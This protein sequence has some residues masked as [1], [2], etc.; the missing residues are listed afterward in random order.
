M[1]KERL[2]LLLADEVLRKLRCSGGLG[3]FSTQ[4]HHAYFLGAIW[5]DH[6]FYDLPSFKTKGVGRALHVL[7]NPEDFPVLERWIQRQERL[8]DEVKA[9]VL[10]LSCHFLADSLWHPLIN[11]LSRPPFGPCASLGLKPGDCHHYIE[12]DLEVFWLDRRGP[13]DGY[14][15]LLT[16]LAGET[17]LVDR[18]IRSFRDL[19]KA[20]NIA[21]IP[22]AARL[23]RCLRWQNV[24]MRQFAHG[25]WSKKRR[26]LLRFRSTQPL[27]VLIVPE[28]SELLCSLRIESFVPVGAACSHDGGY[29]RG[30]KDPDGKLTDSDFFSE[31]VS[32]SASRLLAL[33]IRW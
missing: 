24:L 12:S 9:W 2:H 20:M 7:E 11:R 18:L 10:G 30:H 14:I 3:A 4:E 31:A 8:S 19:L 6:L 22:T 1:P 5:P 33:P 16:A 25:R 29:S 26:L 32:S 28:Q 21:P 15:P 23:R 13:R 17:L 27:G